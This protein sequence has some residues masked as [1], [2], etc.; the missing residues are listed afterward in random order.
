MLSLAILSIGGAIW[1]ALVAMHHY[2]SSLAI[3]DDLS[4]RELEQVSAFIEG[5]LSFIFLIHAAAFVALSR[6]RLL[7]RW[8]YT[9][10]L[11]LMCAIAISGSLL[12]API[13]S[14]AGVY[15]LTIVISAAVLSHY[16]VSDWLSLYL[17]AVVGGM[18]GCYVGVPQT[19]AFVCLSVIGPCV[20]LAF[21][22][23]GLRLLYRRI[24]AASSSS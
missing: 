7:I 4:I 1:R 10:G 2:R 17:G 23:A 11:T 22:G 3:S 13:I 6:R 15:P 9:M 16:L 18:I 14:V 19:D 21:I 5:G 20:V 12:D 8:S 24:V